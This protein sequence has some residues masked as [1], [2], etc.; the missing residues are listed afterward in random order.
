[1]RA[2][3]QAS[4]RPHSVTAMKIAAQASASGGLYLWFEGDVVAEAFEA[5]FEVGDGSGLTDLVEIGF[6]EIAIGQVL[7]EHVI[8]RDEDLVGDGEG[9][10]QSAAAGLEAVELVLEVAALGSRGGERGAD[11]DGAQVDIALPRPTALLPAGA[12]M[13]AGTDAGPGGQVT[14]AQEYAHV[15]ADLGD[16]HGRNQPVDARNLHQERVLVA[17]GL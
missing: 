13:V 10:A 4:E 5:A 17:I 7:G 9:C 8:G 16:Q 15:D 11:Q 1:M 12:L 14:D 3:G 6:A 2:R